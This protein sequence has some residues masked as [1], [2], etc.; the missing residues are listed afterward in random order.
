[1]MIAHIYLFSPSFNVSLFSMCV[2]FC[3]C[4]SVCLSGSVSVSISMSLSLLHLFWKAKI[5]TLTD[6]SLCN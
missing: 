6:H 2:S 4:V 5:E 1:M 3:L